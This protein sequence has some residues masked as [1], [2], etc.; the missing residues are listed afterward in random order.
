M[1]STQS[2]VAACQ[3]EFSLWLGLIIWHTIS[4]NVD[5]TF[6]YLHF[7]MWLH[8][9]LLEQHM[10]IHFEAFLVTTKTWIKDCIS[11]VYQPNAE[12]VLNKLYFYVNVN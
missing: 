4:Y 10:P 2:Y 11:P 12:M 7:L 9:S 5:H 1:G 8:Y 3:R 6:G